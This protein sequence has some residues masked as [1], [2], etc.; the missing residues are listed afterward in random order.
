MQMEILVAWYRN[1]KAFVIIAG[2][3]SSCCI[4]INRFWLA[5][6]LRFF[7]FYWEENHFR[8]VCLI[9]SLSNQIETVEKE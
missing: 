2:T 4:G 3:L 7:V 6:W 9:K 5:E 8:L 1:L